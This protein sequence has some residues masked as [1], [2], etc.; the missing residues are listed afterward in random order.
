M[1]VQEGVGKLRGQS[2]TWL[3]WSESVDPTLVDVEADRVQ[4]LPQ[5]LSTGLTVAACE[6]SPDR[7]KAASAN[8]GVAV[9]NRLWTVN[10]SPA[11][12]PKGGSGFDLSNVGLRHA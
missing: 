1:L 9:P 4:G 6:Q 5:L 12:M 3:P 11:S 2:G 10:L 7:I 8:S